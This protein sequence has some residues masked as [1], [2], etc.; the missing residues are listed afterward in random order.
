MAKDKQFEINDLQINDKELLSRAFKA[1][2]AS[3]K[4]LRAYQAK[5]ENRV[6]ELKSELALKNQELTNVLQSLS[7]GLIVTDLAGSIRTFN[8][9]AAAITEI[10]KDS[11]IGQPINH[12]L[13]FN[14]LPESLDEN[15]FDKISSD[16]RQTF[17]FISSKG[18]KRIINSSTTII[19]SDDNESEGIIINLNDITTL[20][21]LEEEAERKNRLTAMGEI[22]MQVAHEIRNPLGSIELFVSMMKKDFKEES[23]EMELMQHIS[24]A[25]QSMNHIISNLLEYSKPKPII[26]NTTRI[27]FLL[28]EFMEF[29]RFFATQQNIE[30]DLAYPSTNY[31]ITGN[32][33]LI[34][35][36]FHNLFVNACQAMPEGGVLKIDLEKA[37]E[38]DPVIPDRIKDNYI[39][40]KKSV[41]ML[42]ICFTDFGKGMTE[43]TKKKIFDPFFTT[44]EQGTGLGMSIVHKTMTSHGGAILVDSKEGRGTC[45]TLLFPLDSE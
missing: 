16:F 40:E 5:L 37:K 7:N 14:V 35:Q 18:T 30:I 39:R 20:K 2:D 29:S 45:I 8:R 26:R 43:D 31:E 17:E 36:V 24:S 27:N 3:I 21:R 38:T 32:D 9:A 41:S 4:K 11:A 22:A 19:E 34:K 25:V 15:A 28:A 44:R 10:D 33:Q 13:H 12:L 6:E 1:F 42:K 23:G